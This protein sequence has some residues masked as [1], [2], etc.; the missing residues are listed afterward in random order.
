MLMPVAV[1]TRYND[2]ASLLMI[3]IYPDTVHT[4]GH[5]P[6]LG[7]AE[8]E[9]GKRYWTQRFAVSSDA[10]SPWQQIARTYPPARAAW[11]VRGTTPTNVGEIGVEPN[12]EPQQ[13]VF[14]D[15]AIP[16]ADPAHPTVYAAALPAR[17]VAIGQAGGKE[18]FRKWGGRSPTCWRCRP[19]SIRSS[20]TI[21]TTTIPSARTARGWS[22]TPPRCSRGHGDQHHAGRPEGR[23]QA[24]PGGSTG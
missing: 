15:A 13:P 5:E 14:D 8:I 16:R 6:G 21:P 19:P 12:N 4:F 22:T 10:D 3:R 24:Q 20:S 17:F 7:D 9:A 2:D 11:I 23:R 1:Q 18:I